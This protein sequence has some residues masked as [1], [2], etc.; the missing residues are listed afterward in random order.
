MSI[1]LLAPTD[2][3][4]AY[5]NSKSMAKKKKS[6]AEKEKEGDLT[7]QFATTRKRI[8]DLETT[9]QNVFNHTADTAV[10]NGN[11]LLDGSEGSLANVSRLENVD[12]SSAEA[13]E[14]SI[15]VIDV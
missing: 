4:K 15:A 9:Y 6:E 1:L 10:Y 5:G 11:N 14:A 2:I 7:E 12:L 3:D 8:V 13:A